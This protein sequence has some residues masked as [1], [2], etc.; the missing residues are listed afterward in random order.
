MLGT[1]ET[2]VGLNSIM[3][4]PRRENMFLKLFPIVIPCCLMSLPAHSASTAEMTAEERYS[5][6]RT[7]CLQLPETPR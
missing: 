4:L 2:G 5:R 1:L 7:H 3:L 6:T